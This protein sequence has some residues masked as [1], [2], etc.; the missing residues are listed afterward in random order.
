MIHWF[1]ASSYT[2]G[3]YTEDRVKNCIGLLH[4]VP[5]CRFAVLDKFSNLF[6]EAVGSCLDKIEFK[7]SGKCMK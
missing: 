2:P 1:I 7:T 4:Q 5:A 3:T 6:E